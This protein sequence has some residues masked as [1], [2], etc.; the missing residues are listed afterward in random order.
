MDC[1][2]VN[3]RVHVRVEV[4]VLVIDTDRDIVGKGVNVPVRV[5]VDVG[6]S[7]I[8]HVT[9]CESVVVGDRV[10]VGDGDGVSVVVCV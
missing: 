8:V 10:C 1:V 2:A 9:E 4:G 3:V 5:W 6:E 7:V